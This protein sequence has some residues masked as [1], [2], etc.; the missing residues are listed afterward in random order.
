MVFTLPR[1]S[2]SFLLVFLALSLLYLSNAFKLWFQ[3]ERYMEDMRESLKRAPVPFRE[4][5]LAR[6]EDRDRWLTRQ[7]IF[8]LF[9]V[10]AVLFADAMMIWAWME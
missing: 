3:A 1:P 4:R 2:L 8:S 7:R 10:A 6:L 5:F 9:G